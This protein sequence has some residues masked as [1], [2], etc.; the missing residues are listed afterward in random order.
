MIYGT[1]GI[2]PHETEKNQVKKETI[3]QAIKEN[4][5]IIGIGESGLDFF[6]LGTPNRCTRNSIFSKPEHVSF[7]LL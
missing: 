4:N 6:Y 1:Y 5:K 7:T 2:H 3:I